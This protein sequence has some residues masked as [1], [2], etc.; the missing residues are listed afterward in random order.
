MIINGYK[1]VR[2]ASAYINKSSSKC[3]SGIIVYLL[4]HFKHM[5]SD[6]KSHSGQEKIILTRP[7]YG[8][9][10]PFHASRA[11][12]GGSDLG[13]ADEINLPLADFSQNLITSSLGERQGSHRK[14]IWLAKYFLRHLVNRHT[15]RNTQTDAHEHHNKLRPATHGG[16]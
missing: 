10:F 2:D 5:L 15:E 7:L 3:D 11:Y 14:W 8:L 9:F 12:S 6:I 13:N 16:V 4:L 1:F